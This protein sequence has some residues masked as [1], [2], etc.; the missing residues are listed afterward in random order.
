MNHIFTE[1]LQFAVSQSSLNISQP[2]EDIL[3][4][5]IRTPNIT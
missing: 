3:G 2:L 1:C 5:D 4:P